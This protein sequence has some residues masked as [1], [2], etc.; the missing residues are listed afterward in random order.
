MGEGETRNEEKGKIKGQGAC[1]AK[2]IAGIRADATTVG[3]LETGTN[4]PS[5]VGLP[6]NRLKSNLDTIKSLKVENSGQ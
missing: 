4:C 5:R 2:D 1:S 3:K 6:E